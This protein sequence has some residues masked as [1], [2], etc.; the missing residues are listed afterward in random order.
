MRIVGFEWWKVGKKRGIWRSR[1]REPRVSSQ[2]CPLFS[3]TIGGIFFSFSRS[4][5][6]R[7][8]TGILAANLTG[9][10]GFYLVQ[11][12]L[13]FFSFFGQQLAGYNGGSVDTSRF[14]LSTLLSNRVDRQFLPLRGEI[15]SNP[16]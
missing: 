13:M 1:R 7:L 4:G 14:R 3:F 2:R 8:F 11:F 10:R 6:F 9:C 12:Y 16:L 15:S 5:A